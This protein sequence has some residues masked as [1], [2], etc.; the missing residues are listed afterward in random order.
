MCCLTV[1]PRSIAV[2]SFGYRID[3]SDNKEVC[4]D[5]SAEYLLD[6]SNGEEEDNWFS[7]LGTD[8]EAV[9]LL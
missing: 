7:A 3:L 8:D 9:G 6:W 4:N 1:N 2:S 5:S